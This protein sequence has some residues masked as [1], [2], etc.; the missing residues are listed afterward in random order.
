VDAEFFG[1][2]SSK[3]AIALLT[4]LAGEGA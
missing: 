4:G 2:V 3:G 1:E